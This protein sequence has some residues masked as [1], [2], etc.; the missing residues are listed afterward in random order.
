MLLI[1]LLMIVVDLLILT[2][3]GSHYYS[4]P[5]N[6][7]SHRSHVLYDNDPLWDGQQCNGREAP[8]PA[9]DLYTMPWLYR[10]FDTHINDEP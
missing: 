10:S 9:T 7:M 1:T 3:I 8:C 5:G 4:E 6:F 2:L